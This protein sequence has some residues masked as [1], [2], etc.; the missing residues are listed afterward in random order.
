VL[1]FGHPLLVCSGLFLLYDDLLVPLHKQG[2]NDGVEEEE[3]GA[4]KGR[5]ASGWSLLYIDA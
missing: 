4:D 1:I 5:C 3:G 2:L